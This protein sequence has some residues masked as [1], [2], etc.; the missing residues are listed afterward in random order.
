MA[1]QLEA[2]VLSPEILYIHGALFPLGK[3]NHTV[4]QLGVDGD[5]INDSPLTRAVLN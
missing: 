2:L 3:Y 1:R 5:M 4:Q